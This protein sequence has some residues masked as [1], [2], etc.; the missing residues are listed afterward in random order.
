MLH[1]VVHT[2]AWGPRV[3]RMTRLLEAGA[4]SGL[5]T[6]HLQS[7][8]W[9]EAREGAV[10]SRSPAGGL[11]PPGSVGTSGEGAG[12]A[13]GV[14]P[15]D[16]CWHRPRGCGVKWDLWK[17]EVCACQTEGSLL[18]VKCH[19]KGHEHRACRVQ[20]LNW[21]GFLSGENCGPRGGGAGHVELRVQSP[22][23]SGPLLPS[24][25][26]GVSRESLALM[27]G[28]G[29]TLCTGVSCV[30]WA[31]WVTNLSGSCS[32]ARPVVPGEALAAPGVQ[33]G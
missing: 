31:P 13:P 19:W 25:R 32:G 1:L 14:S 17:Q 29:V 20:I 23:V 16:R 3:I 11:Q 33:C 7:W 26:T 30:V 8:A 18:G 9:W 5:G 6:G 12:A 2:A 27:G 24:Q 21:E 22:G 4:S 10:G 15:E 28:L